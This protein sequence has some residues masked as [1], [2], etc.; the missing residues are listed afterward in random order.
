IQKTIG[1]QPKTETLFFNY[2]QKG[3]LVFVEINHHSNLPDSNL[4]Q[5]HRIETIVNNF[6]Q[7]VGRQELIKFTLQEAPRPPTLTE[8]KC[9][10]ESQSVQTLEQISRNINPRSPPFFI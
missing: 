9:E 6:R 3:D 5:N 8:K 2:L 10:F 4:A 1:F 7:E